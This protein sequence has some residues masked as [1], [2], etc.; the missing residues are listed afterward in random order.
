MDHGLEGDAMDNIIV[1]VYHMQCYLAK[2]VGVR[3]G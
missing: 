1:P 3:K 2:V